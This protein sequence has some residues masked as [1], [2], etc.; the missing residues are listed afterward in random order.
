MKRLDGKSV[1]HSEIEVVKRIFK[2]KT[3]V[4]GY[5]VI[6]NTLNKDGFLVPYVVSWRNKDP[7]MVSRNNSDQLLQI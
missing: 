3:S 2:M 1:D 7:K 4:I 5:I 6:A